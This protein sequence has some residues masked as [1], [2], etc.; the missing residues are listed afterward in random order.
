MNRNPCVAN[1]SDAKAPLRAAFRVTQCAA[2]I[3]IVLQSG[4]TP[5]ASRDFLRGAYIAPRGGSVPNLIMGPHRDRNLLAEEF[6]GRTD[7]P[8]V[9]GGYEFDRVTHFSEV[10]YDDQSFYDRHAGGYSRQSETVRT[11]VT[12]R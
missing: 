9:E 10:I 1:R 12:V 8:S 11:G 3:L 7:W 5:R 4:C 2:L 6:A